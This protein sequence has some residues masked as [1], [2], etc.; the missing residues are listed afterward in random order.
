VA[1]PAQEAL[2]DLQ[3]TDTEIDQLRH[4]RSHLPSREAVAAAE[5]AAV[6]AKQ[7]HDTLSAELQILIDRQ[8]ALEKEV[9]TSEAR[10]EQIDK[11][12]RS[13]DIVAARD[14]VKMQEEIDHL[15]ERAS[16]LETEAFEALE[17]QESHDAEL[18]ALAETLASSIEAV[19]SGRGE[20][21]GAEQEIDARLAEL[22]AARSAKVA[23][24]PAHLVTEYERLRKRLGGVGAARLE[25]DQ[26]TGCHLHLSPYD[27]EQVHRAKPEDVLTCESCGRILVR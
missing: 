18:K 9:G 3:H 14:I 16:R 19:R 1:D 13:G 5:K 8:A 10:A 20:V 15:R 22:E 11:R 27:M 26:C 24:V 7:A 21:T 4:R 23:A 17:E 12:M 2:L 6:A 25:G